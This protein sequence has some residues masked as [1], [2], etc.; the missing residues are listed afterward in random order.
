MRKVSLED[1]FQIQTLQKQ[2]R[3]A[4]AIV[5]DCHVWGPMLDAYQ[6]LK[7]SHQQLWNF[8][9]HCR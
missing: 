1:R 7:K 9:P 2:K 8:E 4:K 3:G 5:V 6:K